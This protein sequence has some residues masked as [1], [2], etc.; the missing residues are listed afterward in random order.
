MNQPQILNIQLGVQGVQLVL[1]AL[2][3]LPYNQVADLINVI[4]LQAQQQ[5]NPPP[6]EPATTPPPAEPEPTPQTEGDPQ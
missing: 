1:N 3:T 4:H 2:A 6:A 5:I